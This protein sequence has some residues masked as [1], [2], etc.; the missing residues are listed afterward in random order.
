MLSPALLAHSTLL[1]YL[2]VCFAPIHSETALIISLTSTDR[3]KIEKGLFNQP[4]RLRL[5]TKLT[6]CGIFSI[7][8]RAQQATVHHH[9]LFTSLS[10][11]ADLG[12]KFGL[13]GNFLKSIPLRQCLFYGCH[14][15][16]IMYIQCMYDVSVV[17]T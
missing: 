5:I 2:V 10:K 15:H 4:S 8:I 9:A 11:L 12:M 1:V 16:P 3:V 6:I 14:G 13:K 7:L 17:C